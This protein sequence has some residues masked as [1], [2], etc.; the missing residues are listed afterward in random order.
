M[1][2]YCNR[3][4]SLSSGDVLFGDRWY[5]GECWVNHRAEPQPATEEASER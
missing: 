2:E 5:H 4:V 1:C 3:E